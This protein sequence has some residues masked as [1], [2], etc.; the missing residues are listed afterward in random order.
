[1]LLT[2]AFPDLTDAPRICGLVKLR[3]TCTRFML[4]DVCCA[5]GTQLCELRSQTRLPPCMKEAGCP[6]GICM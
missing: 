2:K 5:Y 6:P 3:K 4:C 1:M